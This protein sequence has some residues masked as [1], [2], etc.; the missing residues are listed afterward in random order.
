MKKFKSIWVLATL[1][2]FSLHGAGELE[3]PTPVQSDK[4]L[5]HLVSYV[6]IGK[7]MNDR[8]ARLGEKFEN[9]R[10]LPHTKQ[11]LYTKFC[12][13]NGGFSQ[14]DK[15][16]LLLHIQQDP[17]VKLE[18]LV[19]VM[20]RME[21]LEEP[22]NQNAADTLHLISEK[23]PI[24]KYANQYKTVLDDYKYLVKS[25]EK[26]G[27][28]YK[29]LIIEILNLILAHPNAKSADKN[30]ASERLARLMQELIGEGNDIEGSEVD[31]LRGSGQIP[32]TSHESKDPE[33]LELLEHQSVIDPAAATGEENEENSSE[34][35]E[36]RDWEIV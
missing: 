4:I 29:P 5:T 12:L 7:K 6:E 31:D 33:G 16:S 30:K 36:D 9:E 22:Y 23:W 17:Q 34:E 14:K 35:G 2:S 15:Y 8:L 24:V 1:I 19:F 3:F 18:T 32:V 20:R 26:R 13:G 10:T 27:E 25:F 28:I 11:L 21:T